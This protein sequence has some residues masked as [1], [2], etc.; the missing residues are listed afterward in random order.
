[1]SSCGIESSLRKS[2]ARPGRNDRRLTPAGISSKGTLFPN[3][4]SPSAADREVSRKPSLECPEPILECAHE[5]RTARYGAGR[6]SPDPLRPAVHE[7]RQHKGPQRAVHMNHVVATA[8]DEARRA[9]EEADLAIQ[10]L[11]DVQF[12][13]S[14]ASRRWM[15]S[16]PT[17]SRAGSFGRRTAMTLT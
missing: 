8:P 12:I 15:Q 4:L 14:G 9:P 5:R 13:V 16:V 10:R 1:M 11:I 7:R 17:R 6:M 3:N 2:R